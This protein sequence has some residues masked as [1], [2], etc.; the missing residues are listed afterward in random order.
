MGNTLVQKQAK[1]I[2]TVANCSNIYGPG[3]VPF[4]EIPFLIKSFSQK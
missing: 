4:Q 2:I 3:Y 1:T